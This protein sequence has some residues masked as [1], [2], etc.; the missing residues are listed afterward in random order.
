[1]AY[2]M[3]EDGETFSNANNQICQMSIVHLTTWNIQLVKCKIVTNDT[4]VHCVYFLA[5]VNTHLELIDLNA[6][7]EMLK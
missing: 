7:N 4:F 3:E 2:P 6:F 5:M 1:M